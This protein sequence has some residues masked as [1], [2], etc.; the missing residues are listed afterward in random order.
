MFAYYNTKRVTYLILLITMISCQGKANTVANK[1]SE[2]S[3]ITPKLDSTE[4]GELRLKGPFDLDESDPTS[5]ISNFINSIYQDAEGSYW[6]GTYGMGVIHYDGG[7]TLNFFSVD[8]GLGGKDIREI[9]N[10]EEGN[11]WMATNGG[12]TKY[13]GKD[14][15]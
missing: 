11:I 9:I 3:I 13:N 4:Q 8:D 1:P 2:Q 7:D 6:F 10:D 15:L 5:R 14:W 12:L